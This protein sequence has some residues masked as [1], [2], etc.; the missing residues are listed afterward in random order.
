MEKD[1]EACLHEGYESLLA[2]S[3]NRT[4]SEVH[5]NH[6]HQRYECGSSLAFLWTYI[7]SSVDFS[8]ISK[9]LHT[10]DSWIAPGTCRNGC[11]Q[12]GITSQ[13]TGKQERVYTSRF[14][15]CFDE[16]WVLALCNV[17]YVTNQILLKI[18]QP[19]KIRVRKE[20]KHAWEIFTKAVH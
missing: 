11:S 20:K 4:C 5:K 19:S 2:N 18:Q 17:L 15:Q 7:F 3:T 16:F 9:D 10:S 6:L 12:P 14:F 8:E 13:L 1:V